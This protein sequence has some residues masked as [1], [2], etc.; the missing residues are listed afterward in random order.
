MKKQEQEGRCVCVDVF[1]YFLAMAKVLLIFYS[2]HL[3]SNFSKKNCAFSSHSVFRS[4][5][6]KLLFNKSDLLPP[7]IAANMAADVCGGNPGG[8][9]GKA[10]IMDAA[11]VP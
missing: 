10:L 8:G 7:F 4:Q 9:G 11:E 1:E 5:F 2:C 6:F 3:L